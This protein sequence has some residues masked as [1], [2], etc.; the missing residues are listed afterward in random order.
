M[1]VSQFSTVYT[2]VHRRCARCR[3]PLGRPCT[4]EGWSYRI[5]SGRRSVGPALD[6]AGDA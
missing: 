6:A 3:Y 5:A 4:R 1:Q 2:H